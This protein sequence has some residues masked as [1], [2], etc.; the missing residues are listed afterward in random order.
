MEPEPHKRPIRFYEIDLLRFLAALSVVFYHYTFRGYSLGHYSPLAFPEL[1]RFTRY[2]YL[3]VELFF[4]ISGYVVLLSAQGKTIRQFFLSRITRLYPA[5]WVACTLTFIVKLLWGTGPADVGMSPLL[6][7]TPV[8]YVVNMSM[9]PEF[10]HINAMD[11]AY[12]SLTIE[13]TFYLLIAILI[14]FGLLKHLTL[15]LA[16]WLAYTALPGTMH[17]GGLFPALFFPA[18]APYFAAGMLLYLMQQPEGRTWQ[19]YALLL[20]T[21]VLGLRASID[22]V[23]SLALAYHE[24]FSTKVVAAIITGCYVV[25]YL[26]AFR[27]IDL[28]RFS[29]LAWLGALTYPLY[30]LHSDIGFIIFHRMQHFT[31]KYVLVGGTMVLMLVAAYLVHVFIEKRLSKALGQQVNRLLTALAK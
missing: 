16:L 19:R 20:V 26:V 12:W 15:V 17:E 31:N 11:G 21:Y 28:S 29:W 23:G 2:G 18:Y 3:G 30:L 22:H 27:K 14:G 1:G 9:L 6:H 5:L 25:M 4:I 7:A 8:Q 24:P 10:F 13:I